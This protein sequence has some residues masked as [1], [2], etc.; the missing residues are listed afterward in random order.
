M[1]KKICFLIIIALLGGQEIIAQKK[2]AKPGE[3]NT[4]ENNTAY[5]EAL[6]QKIQGN[7]ADA[8]QM[9]EEILKKYPNDHAS[10][11]ELADIY[12]IRNEL[13]LA[14]KWAT[15]ASECNP[16]NDWY[17]LSLSE[18]YIKNHEPEKSVAVMERLVK[19]NP[20]N[21]DYVENLAMSYIFVGEY[22]KAVA[23]LNVI[24][25]QQGVS[26]ELSMEKF[27]IYKNIGKNK[28]A[29]AE[30]EKLIKYFPN[31]TRYYSLLADAY[32]SMG[33][34]KD[35]LKAYDK[36]LEINPKDPYIHIALADYYRQEG[37]LKKAK[38]ELK[39]GFTNP[40][41]DFTT[42]LQLV[43]ALVQISRQSGNLS[44]NEIKEM[45]KTII[46][47]HPDEP[48]AW[49]LY[50]DIALQEKNYEEAQRALVKMVA[51]DST[52]YST[53][54]MLLYTDYA[55]ND[56][57]AL[58][59]HAATASRFF[60][61]QPLPFFLGG[62]ANYQ[63][64]NYAK[65]VQMLERGKD[66]V[67]DDPKTLED[68]YTLLGDSYHQLKNEE[69][70]FYY[71]EKVLE[72]NPK[73]SIVLN[74]YAYYLALAGKE[75]EKAEKMSFESL[76]IDANNV[77]NMDTYGWIMYKM[78]RYNDAALWI[79]KALEKEPDNGTLNDHYGDIMY[80]LGKTDDAVNY[81]K[82]AKD[83][84]D[85]EIENLDKK[86]GERKLEE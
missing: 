12:G 46:Q 23:Q 28:K 42:K 64:G 9:F 44:D 45:L 36:I 66:F 15:K 4:R 35:A 63:L 6:N 52:R 43:G 62:I 3:E 13:P 81:W 78:G 69:K 26:E 86:I 80:K 21:M 8:I 50:A 22:E 30:I 65:A 61:L 76:K 17:Y 48:E 41:L 60:P 24:E 56:Y 38:E 14:I 37:D 27:E 5:I 7:Y 79:K 19:R 70:C 29:I 2:V 16:E 84:G 53:W 47:A 74:N 40:D 73:S 34:K 67:F 72:K 25:L 77:N 49:G 1:Y 83:S 18:L 10:M 58:S 39:I 33:M 55:L 32:L 59:Q 31:E 57:A 75:L 68:F 54:E 11:Y 20:S 82:K 71:Y 51:S 85:K